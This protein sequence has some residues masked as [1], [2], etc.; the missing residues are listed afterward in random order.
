LLNAFKSVFKFASV[1]SQFHVSSGDFLTDVDHKGRYCLYAGSVTPVLYLTNGR[2]SLN[3]WQTVLKSKQIL[4][5][6]S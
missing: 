2:Y 5:R 3:K 4:K 1:S 6:F